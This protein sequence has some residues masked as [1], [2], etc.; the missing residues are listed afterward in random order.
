MNYQKFEP[1]DFILDESFQDWVLSPTPTSEEFW[2]AWIRQNPHK[3]AVVQ[4]AR[5]IL[6][7]IRLSG[8][9]SGCV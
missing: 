1:I 2:Q 6:L 7:N 8:C 9:Q 4:Q 5:A 3:E